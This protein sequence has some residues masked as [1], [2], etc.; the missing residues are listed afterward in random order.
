MRTL[1]RVGPILTL[2]PLLL[3]AAVWNFALHEENQAWYIVWPIIALL[4]L[5]AIWHVALIIFEKGYRLP[6]LAYALVH[7]PIFWVV[8]VIALIYATRFPL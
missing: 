4:G 8:Y 6:Y 7:M 5:T 3:W 1:F 2:A